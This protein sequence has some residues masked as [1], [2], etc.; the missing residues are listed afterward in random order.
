MTAPVF[1]H[2]NARRM[3]FALLTGAAL[4][5][6]ALAQGRRSLDVAAL[7][8]RLPTEV[9]DHTTEGIE[10]DELRILQSRGQSENWKIT[11]RTPGKVVIASKRPFSEINL[12]PASEGGAVFV[13]A[14]TFN[15]KAINY[16]YWIASGPGGALQAYTPSAVFRLLN[17]RPD[18]TAGIREKDAPRMI[19]EHVRL[20]ERCA[21]VEGQGASR[22]VE[23]VD[24]AEKAVQLRQHFASQPR[25]TQIIDRIGKVFGDKDAS[26]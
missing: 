11:R 14:L 22:P 24:L 4:S 12:R 16:E 20:R 26:S 18:G 19:V 5:S 1:N 7:V 2:A 23:C 25:W 21:K 13:E 3:L 9:F 10:A 8:P 17:E 15:E 6:P